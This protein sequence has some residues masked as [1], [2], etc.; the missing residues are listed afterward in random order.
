MGAF[1]QI[2]KVENHHEEII[3][4]PGFDA[5]EVEVIVK[6]V[7]NKNKKSKAGKKFRG[8]ISGK[9]AKA[10]LQYVEKS[11]SEWERNI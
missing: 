4:P 2:V 6:P 7:K 10:M 1:R 11:R 8:V 9:T 5:S 3:L